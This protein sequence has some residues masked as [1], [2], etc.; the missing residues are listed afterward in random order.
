MMSVRTVNKLCGV[1]KES[2]R[3]TVVLS[4]NGGLCEV[5]TM[6]TIKSETRLSVG[7]GSTH[8]LNVESGGG[9]RLI[10]AVKPTWGLISL[11]DVTSSA[12]GFKS[13]SDDNV[14]PLD[15]ASPRQTPRSPQH[16]QVQTSTIET[17]SPNHRT[18][19]IT[20]PEWET[21]PFVCV[22]SEACCSKAGGCLLSANMSASKGTAEAHL[23]LFA[24][25]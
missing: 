22:S 20:H 10:P 24:V 23:L 17:T 21:G 4:H 6:L 14:V 12:T 15:P 8:G 11:H 16:S 9:A 13:V 2:K 3:F 5:W 7:V 1:T 19:H 18:V 25:R